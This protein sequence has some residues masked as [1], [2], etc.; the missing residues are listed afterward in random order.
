MADWNNDNPKTMEISFGIEMNEDI[1]DYIMRLSD[2]L[3]SH[4][5]V[6]E[7]RIE[8]QFREHISLGI[9]DDVPQPQRIYDQILELFTAGYK[10]GWNDHLNLTREDRK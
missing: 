8:Q 2:E 5:E 6:M 7:K 10:L 3:K 1:K 4:E 9:N